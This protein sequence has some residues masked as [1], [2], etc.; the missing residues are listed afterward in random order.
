M[1]IITPP[2]GSADDDALGQAA[3]WLMALT[4]ATRGA[5]DLHALVPRLQAWLEGGGH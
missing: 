4:D 2:Y 5:G 3:D 1:T